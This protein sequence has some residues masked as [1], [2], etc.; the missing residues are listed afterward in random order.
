M[1]FKEVAKV[2][3]F[4]VMQIVLVTCVTLYHNR[5]VQ[6]PIIAWYAPIIP[7]SEKILMTKMSCKQWTRVLCSSYLL[8][9]NKR[10][11]CW[12]NNFNTFLELNKM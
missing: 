1:T 12:L 2:A 6:W 11:R 4:I 5:I 10:I 7:W 9:H 8:F 3:V